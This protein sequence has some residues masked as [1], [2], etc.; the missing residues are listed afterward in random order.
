MASVSKT[1]SVREMLRAGARPVEVAAALNV[2]SHTVVAVMEEMEAAPE[3]E[4]SR[5]LC[6]DDEAQTPAE[7]VE[8]LSPAAQAAVEDLLA[9]GPI[10]T[11]KATTAW[12]AHCCAEMPP[13]VRILRSEG[14][15][16]DEGPCIVDAL[17]RFNYSV[18]LCPWCGA[19]LR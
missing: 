6:A 4:C 12:N 8:P 13:G 5:Q 3:E 18:N 19:K 14:D 11:M 10:G 15:E 17:N 9:D 16:F 7:Y 1:E 2:P